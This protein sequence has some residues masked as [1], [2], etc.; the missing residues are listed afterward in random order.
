VTNHG[1]LLAGWTPDGKGL[2]YSTRENPRVG[3]RVDVLPGAEFRTGPS[4]AV[5]QIPDDLI[6]ITAAHDGRR[7]LVS[8]LAGKAPPRALTVLQD[9]PAALAK[10]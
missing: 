9:W 3:L 10:R 4:R 2:I 7:L 6:G 1:G 8:R 5:A